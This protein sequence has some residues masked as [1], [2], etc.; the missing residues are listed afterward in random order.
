MN[1]FQVKG[2]RKYAEDD[3]YIVIGMITGIKVQY[4]TQGKI[5]YIDIYTLGREINIYG[6][7]QCQQVIDFIKNNDDLFKEQKIIFKE[8]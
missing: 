5:D 7:Y 3:F 2:R 6:E 8:K 4:D 1:I